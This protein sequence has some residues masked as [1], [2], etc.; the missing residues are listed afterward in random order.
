MITPH[1]LWVGLALLIV[2]LFG[3]VRLWP[4]GGYGKT[5]S[6][7]IA[8]ARTGI[9]YYTLVFALTLP[10]FAAFF[11][12]WFIPAYQPSILFNI[13]ISIALISQFLC[14]L[15]PEIGHKRKVAH[16]ALALVS[17]LGLLASMVVALVSGSFGVS[18]KIIL[19]VG[20]AVMTWLLTVMIV[21]NAS[22]SKILFV[23]AG[24]FAAFFTSVLLVVYL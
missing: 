3:A 8:T 23:Q 7:H 19:F 14:T 9:I 1:I 24:Y 13:F 6:Q 18:D 2:G 21:T 4:E 5:F 11:F 20:S 12:G 15:V 22:H 10:L 16:R 17:A